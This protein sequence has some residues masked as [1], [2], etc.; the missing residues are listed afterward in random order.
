MTNTIKH[1]H[2]EMYDDGGKGI[3]R[4]LSWIL[5]YLLLNGVCR[6]NVFLFVISQK[7]MVL[8]CLRLK[9]L[10]QQQMLQATVFLA[11]LSM[12]QCCGLPPMLS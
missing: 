3:Y 11:F 1:E 4:H 7:L 12:N 10:S 5:C 9:A 8:R 6:L 2:A